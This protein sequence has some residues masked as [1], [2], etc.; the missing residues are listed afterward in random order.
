M[1]RKRKKLEFI[2]DVCARP[3]ETTLRDD[4][5]E[6]L[7]DLLQIT[8]PRDGRPEV[9]NRSDSVTQ[10]CLYHWA[11]SIQRVGR[12]EEEGRSQ[13]SRAF[14]KMILMLVGVC[15]LSMNP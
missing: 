13:V 6:T 3:L 7:S 5:L 4:G 12:E 10:L 15:S 14:T 11:L 1:T 8:Q 2:E 9:Q